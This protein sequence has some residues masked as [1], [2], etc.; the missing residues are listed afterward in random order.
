MVYNSWF[1]REVDTYS[2]L[3]IWVSIEV[4]HT[5]GYLK[6][7]SYADMITM[8]I[9]VEDLILMPADKSRIAYY[10]ATRK[11]KNRDEESDSEPKIT[12]CRFVYATPERGPQRRE[13][14]PNCQVD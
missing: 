4:R 14:G 1:C 13:A 3:C 10:G 2:D 8:K 7:T 9:P 11:R 12:V 5:I 6:D